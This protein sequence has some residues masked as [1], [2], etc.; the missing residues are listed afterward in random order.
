MYLGNGLNYINPFILI[1]LVQNISV[2]DIN[3][4]QKLIFGRRK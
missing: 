2:I 3:I 4:K 1:V